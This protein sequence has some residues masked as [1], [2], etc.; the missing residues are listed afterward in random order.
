MEAE[1]SFSL[2]KCRKHDLEAGI[3]PALKVKK[4]VPEQTPKASITCLNHEAGNSIGWGQ[5][6]IEGHGGWRCSGRR[7]RPD[8]LNF[9]RRGKEFDNLK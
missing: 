6:V 2:K 3:W 1:T 8:H 5:T 7:Q 4:E 9:V